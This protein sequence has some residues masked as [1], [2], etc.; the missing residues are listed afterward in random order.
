MAKKDRIIKEKVEHSGVF[1][2]KGLYSYV[3]SLLEDGGYGVTEKKYVENISDSKRNINI[4]WDSFKEVSDYFKILMEVRIDVSNLVDV[5]AEIEGKK[6]KM[7]KGKIAVE[8]EAHLIH[9]YD[10]K[11]EGSMFKVFLRDIYDKYVIPHR[12]HN[13]EAKIVGDV[14]EFKESVKGFLGLEGKR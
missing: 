1:D 13:V 6:K 14:V 5:E 10:G 3:H 11:W 4:E 12:V 7:N 2:F 9:D 8:F